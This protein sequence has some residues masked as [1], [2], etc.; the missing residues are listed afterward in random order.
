MSGMVF[1]SK[2][3]PRGSGGYKAMTG[4][5]AMIVILSTGAF[6]VFLFFEVS[7]RRVP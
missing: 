6:V 4:F 5:V 1:V 7:Q 3:F 2:G